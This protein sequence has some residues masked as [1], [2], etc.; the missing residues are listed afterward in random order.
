FGFDTPKEKGHTT[1]DFLK[2]L[3]VGK[4][5]GYLGLGGNLARA[6]PDQGR[7]HEVWGNM[8]LTAHVA[9]RLNRTHLLPGKQSYV[10]PCLVRAEED[11][12][13]SGPQT[14]T[15]EDSFSHIYGSIGRRT[16]ASEHLKSEVAIVAG[17]AKATLPPN[18]RWQ[19]D[20]WTSDYAIV[21]D[22]IAKT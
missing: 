16:P 6:V 19:W 20:T 7:V 4:T 1:V 21:R 22:L 8:E 10:L 5:K 2:S 14:V 15:I 11:L 18:P 12:Q 17:L 13:A 9:T 3:L